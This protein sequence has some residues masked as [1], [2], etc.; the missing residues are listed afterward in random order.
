MVLS[1]GFFFL[2]PGSPALPKPLI[3]PGLV[4]FSEQ[5]RD[6][7]EK[8]LRRKGED[9]LLQN[10]EHIPLRVVWKTV[11]HWRRW[12]HFFSTFCVFSTWSPLTTYTPSILML[13]P[14]S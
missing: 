3:G 4:R 10:G 6:I 9:E 7:L 12:P 2:L 1:L 5:D 14:S 11:K 13:V 8:R